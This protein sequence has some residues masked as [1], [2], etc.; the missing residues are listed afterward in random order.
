MN[1]ERVTLNIQLHRCLSFVVLT[2]LLSVFPLR[3]GIAQTNLTQTGSTQTNLSF[4]L[5]APTDFQ[6]LQYYYASYQNSPAPGTEQG[7]FTVGSNRTWSGDWN[8]GVVPTPSRAQLN[9]IT[10]AQ[11]DLFNRAATYTN[12]MWQIVTSQTNLPL[13]ALT[14]ISSSTYMQIRITAARDKQLA[15]CQ[16]IQLQVSQQQTNSP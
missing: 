15:T 16:R 11:V 2:V 8:S 13:S 7:I 4:A 6:R 9:A 10:P 3:V 14:V 5:P 12:G 1:I